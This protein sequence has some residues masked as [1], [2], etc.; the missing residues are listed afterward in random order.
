MSLVMSASNVGPKPTTRFTPFLEQSAR[1][2]EMTFL[3]TLRSA[4]SVRLRCTYHWLRPISRF[5][6]AGCTVAMLRAHSEG[7]NAVTGR[8]NAATPAEAT[9]ENMLTFEGEKGWITARELS[10]DVGV[11]SGVAQ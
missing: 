2:S 6:T 3:M 1:R 10:L 4:P 8:R 9:R 5:R 7:V 11:R